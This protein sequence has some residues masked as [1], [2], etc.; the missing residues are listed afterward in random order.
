MNGQTKLKLLEADYKPDP[1]IWRQD[2]PRVHLLK[3]IVFEK[4]DQADRTLILI[5]AELR[6]TRKMAEKFQV[7]QMTIQRQITRIRKIIK[8]EYLKATR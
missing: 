2:T 6:S 4:L 5:Y 1:T 7:S 3:K 8:D